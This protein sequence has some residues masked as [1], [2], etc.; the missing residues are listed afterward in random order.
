MAC[1]YSPSVSGLR[2]TVNTGT[3]SRGHDHFLLPCPDLSARWASLSARLF[4][5]LRKYAGDL[6]PSMGK[7]AVK[8][9]EDL[10]GRDSKNHS[11]WTRQT[12]SSANKRMEVLSLFCKFGVPCVLDLKVSGDHEVKL[13]Q[14][15]SSR[16]ACS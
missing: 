12:L 16:G 9:K 4:S 3:R 6:L 7:I 15:A 11:T 1:R 14:I 13:P 10:E 2:A 8:Q 5:R